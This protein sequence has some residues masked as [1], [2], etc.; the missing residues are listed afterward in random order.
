[1]SI[2]DQLE[3]NLLDGITACL[4]RLDNDSGVHNLLEYN[5]S[6]GEPTSIAIRFRN[7]Q[8][9]SEVIRSQD[10][11]RAI[12]PYFSTKVRCN[13]T[14]EFENWGGLTK[15]QDVFG[16]MKLRHMQKRLDVP[17]RA[18]FYFMVRYD[19]SM[20]LCG[21]RFYRSDMDDMIVGNLREQSLIE[22]SKNPKT[23]EIIK[24]FY[25]GQRPETCL[26]CSLYHRIN[27]MWLPERQQTTEAR[28]KNPAAQAPKQDGQPVAAPV[29]AA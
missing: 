1:L 22:I 6:K 18:L 23:W 21:C 4:F 8:K 11:I 14:V 13:F 10:F 7:A 5:R 3:K 26:G 27:R 9:P 19:G 15:D 24:G 12:K 2:T 28:S 20:R 16:S 17:C 25:S 29:V